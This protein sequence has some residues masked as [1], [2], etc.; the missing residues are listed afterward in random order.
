LSR[1]TYSLNLVSSRCIRSSSS[2]R[3]LQAMQ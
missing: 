2:F 3:I 1:K